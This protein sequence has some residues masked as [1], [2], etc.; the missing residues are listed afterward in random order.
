[1]YGFFL[2]ISDLFILVKPALFHLLFFFVLLPTVEY[3][4]KKHDMQY[5]I[6]LC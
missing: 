5:K 3:N 6:Q 4:I 1:M 2:L